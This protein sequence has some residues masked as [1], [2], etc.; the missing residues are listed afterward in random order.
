MAGPAG[1][2]TKVQGRVTARPVTQASP[3]KKKAG[4][5]VNRAVEGMTSMP[6]KI[7]LQAVRETVPPPASPPKKLGPSTAGARKRR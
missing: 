4:F 5:K 7:R 2:P 1:K 3:P 6:Q